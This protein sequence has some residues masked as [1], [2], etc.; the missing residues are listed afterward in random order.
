MREAEKFHLRRTF[1]MCGAPLYPFMHWP[2]I[3]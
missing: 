1:R 3:S 2:S